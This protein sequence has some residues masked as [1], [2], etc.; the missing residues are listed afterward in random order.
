MIG[1][2]VVYFLV[3]KKEAKKEGEAMS[4]KAKEVDEELRHLEDEHYP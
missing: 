3:P 4:E 1:L 2:V